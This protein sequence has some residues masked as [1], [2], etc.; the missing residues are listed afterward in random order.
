M[1]FCDARFNNKEIYIYKM[2]TKK[3]TKVRKESNI[4]FVMSKQERVVLVTHVQEMDFFKSENK[5]RRFS[6]VLGL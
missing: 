6:F 1:I 4:E 3:E 2:K 5:R